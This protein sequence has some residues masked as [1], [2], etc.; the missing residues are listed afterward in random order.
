MTVQPP[1]PGFTAHGGGRVIGGSDEPEVVD[2]SHPPLR[3]ATAFTVGV[4]DTGVV[5]DSR[6][7]AHPWFGRDHLSYCPD[8]DEDVLAQ[9]AQQRAS[10]DGHGTFVAGLVL[11]EAPAAKV[12][13][14]GVLDK[15]RVPT[16]FDGLIDQDDIAVA[17]A[18]G[19]LAVNPHVQVINLSFG[20]GVWAERERPTRLERALEELFELRDN[21]AVVASAGNE[22]TDSPVWPAAFPNV[23]AVGALD[24]A[25]AVARGSAPPVAPF[26]N[27][28]P[29]IDA[30]ANG[31]K[32]LGPYQD[33]DGAPRW[34]RW[35]GTSFAAAIVTGRIAQVAIERGISGKQAAHAVLSESGKI[36]G[37]RAVWVRGIDSL[38]FA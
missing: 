32:A 4:I 27:T 26:S 23:I 7:R 8:E 37:S 22:S 35:S 19:A 36:K 33:W 1:G 15:N 6:R 28:G 14:W 21:V 17:A 5:L 11:R 24:E 30:Y 25:A 18:L 38:P 12:R 9:G 20:G 16:D 13:M 10:S 34:A 3:P 29:F 2:A 31:V